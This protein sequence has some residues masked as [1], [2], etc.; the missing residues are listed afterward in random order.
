MHATSQNAS[1]HNMWM[2][3]A[4]TRTPHKKYSAVPWFVLVNASNV[5]MRQL[6]FVFSAHTN[7]IANSLSFASSLPDS[8]WLLQKCIWDLA[9]SRCNS[10]DAL[11]NFSCRP[12]SIESR[13][14]QSSFSCWKPSRKITNKI[15]KGMMTR[16]RPL[17]LPLHRPPAST[18]H[19]CSWNTM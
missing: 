3:T 8:D 11:S 6:T 10:W 14:C 12:A 13:S 15:C 9:W 5:L 17:P 7:T 19:A 16:W 1:I 4:A 18:F 2:H